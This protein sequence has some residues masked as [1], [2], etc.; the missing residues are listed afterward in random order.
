MI[1]DVGEKEKTPFYGV[2]SRKLSAAGNPRR[3][4]HL[5][6]GQCR[7]EA[8]P[9][10]PDPYL[11]ISRLPLPMPVMKSGKREGKPP[12]LRIKDRNPQFACR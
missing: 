12:V 2:Y 10:P 4:G 11:D 1:S 6:K 3:Q 7:G 8:Q 9:K 5:G